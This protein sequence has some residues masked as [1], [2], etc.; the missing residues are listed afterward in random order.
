MNLD[1]FNELNIENKNTNSFIAN[2]IKELV[3]KLSINKKNIFKRYPSDADSIAKYDKSND[4]KKVSNGDVC[5]VSQVL[6]ER[7]SFIDTDNGKQF[8]IYYAIND[9]KYKKLLDLGVNPK[10]ICSI[11]EDEFYNIQF[12]DKFINT[13]TNIFERYEGDL[14]IQNLKIRNSTDTDVWY[15]LDQMEDTLKKLEGK[16]YIVSDM[17]E[18]KIILTEQ[19]IGGNV[20]TYKK[21]YPNVNVGDVLTRRG[22]KYIKE[23]SNNE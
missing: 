20:V 3:E 11:H 22:R 8:D 10:S 19:E 12:G 2:F 7:V 13:G 18:E 6:D 23:S 5:V 1:E 14:D 21:L 17:N 16:R 9:E 4:L 15:D